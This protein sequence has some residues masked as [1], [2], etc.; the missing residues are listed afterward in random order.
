MNT[1]FVYGTYA[2]LAVVEEG[3]VIEL[4]KNEDMENIKENGFTGV[5][6]FHDTKL[7]KAIVYR[8]AANGSAPSIDYAL[9]LVNAY[10]RKVK[11]EACPISQ[12]YEFGTDDT[13]KKTREII[14][15]YR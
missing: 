8:A 9:D 14:N 11:T 4:I 15:A 2:T 10:I 3:T 7:L 6:I 5:G 12:L 13:L 1:G